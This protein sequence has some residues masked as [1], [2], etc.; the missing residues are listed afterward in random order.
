MTIVKAGE[1]TLVVSLEGEAEIDRDMKLL[2]S[3]LI[4]RSM[5]VNNVSETTHPNPKN[6]RQ[7]T[8]EHTFRFSFRKADKILRWEASAVT[9]RIIDV[10]A[11]TLVK[12]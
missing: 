11:R 7:L 12:E 5:N 1:L 6:R 8:R 4:A 3:V 2:T 9:G 10:S